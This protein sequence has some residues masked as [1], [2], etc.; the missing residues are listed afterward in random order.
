MIMIESG[1]AAGAGGF[2]VLS[3]IQRKQVRLVVGMMSGT[4]ADGVDAAL[5]EIRGG[6]APRVRMVSF[7]SVPY[8]AGVR[9]ELF[10]L[11]QPTY[12]SVDRVGAMHFLLGELYA[13]AAL[14]VIRGAGLTARDVDLIGSHGQTIWH[15]PEPQPVLG[16]LLR[17]S[18][19]IGE[20]AVIAARTG[21]VTVSDFRVADLAAGGL[22]APLVPYTE[23]LLYRREAETVLLQ[24]IGGI[25]NMT[26][27]PAG[28]APEQVFAF[29]TGPGNMIIDA[30]AAA[31]TG[32][33][34]TF[35]RDGAMAGRGRVQPAL[36]DALQQHPYY[37]RP[38]PKTTGR[39]M[40]G[41]QYTEAML[42]WP[43]ARGISPEDLAATVTELTAWSIADAY[44][45]YVLPR[46]RAAELVVSGGGSC[47]P[48][49][50]ACL[51]RRFAPH[52]VAVCTQEALGWRSD[53]KEA[54]AFALLAD[55]CIREEVNTLPSVTGARAPAVMG[56]IS[57][58]AGPAPCG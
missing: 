37:A 17:C 26:V 42:G 38:L 45:R 14:S 57:L 4:S 11:F 50:L 41:T 1:T 27:L 52:G 55:R 35:D 43:A 9:A 22:G 54:V 2:A 40:F 13:E 3:G 30:V 34:E 8:P 7:E 5:V 16:R 32:G 51:R 39:E 36:L 23:Y 29:D 58:P 19:Q 56:K 21:I 28:A 24:N 12:A 53:A 31:A 47:N 49:L 10:R 15:Q 48:T 46:Y 33:R 18:V 25:G 20:G 44:E 6:A